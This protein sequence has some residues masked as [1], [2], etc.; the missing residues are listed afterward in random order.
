MLLA[1][2]VL[3]PGEGTMSLEYHVSFA[4]NCNLQLFNQN[5]NRSMHAIMHFIYLL[6]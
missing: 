3:K 2:G 1:A 5:L 4:Y 6:L